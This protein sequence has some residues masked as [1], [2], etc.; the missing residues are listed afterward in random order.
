MVEASP[1]V[2]AKQL[3]AR[4]ERAAGLAAD[5]TM[6]DEAIAAEV[7]V[8]R[9][10]LTR[11]RANPAFVARV[12]ELVEAARAEARAKTIAEKQ[13]R[14]DQANDRHER[15]R[16]LIE[17]RA[18]QHEEI[19]GGDTGLLVAEPKMVKV[20]DADR[21]N[22]R[23]KR[24]DDYADEEDEDQLTPTGRVMVMFTY[25]A[26]TALLAEMRATEK[27]VAIELG[28]WTEKG[29]TTLNASEAFVAAMAEWG[30]HGGDS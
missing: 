6:S 16:K 29:E 25:K 18:K 2:P 20:F 4:E 28:E 9:R 19:P 22:R 14:V 10:T 26:D 1:N 23:G 17:A 3:S 13:F 30:T 21:R 7:G 8:N 24:T 11:W 5:D 12:A 15:M 27:Q